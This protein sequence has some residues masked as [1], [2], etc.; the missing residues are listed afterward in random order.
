MSPAQIKPNVAFIGLCGMGMLMARRL[1]D[2]GWTVSGYDI[3][4]ATTAA[5][6]YAGGTASASPALAATNASIL[7]LMVARAEHIMS[8]LFAPRTG[9][10]HALTENATI[11]LHCTVQPT[12][13]Q[14]V[15]SRLGREYRR[16]DVVVM[17]APVIGSM[18]GVEDGTLTIMI[19]T[20]KVNYLE[21]PDI[22]DLLACMTQ[23]VHHIS[24]PLGS[25]LKVKLLN[26]ALCGIHIV[27]AAE[28]MGLAA[29]MALDT[30]RF[31]KFVTGP[32]PELGRR[33]NCWSWIFEDCVPRML[34]DK[35]P[36]GF[37]MRNV[38]RDVRIVNNEAEKFGA[39]LSL[40]KA[41]QFVYEE[42]VEMGFEDADDSAVLKTYLRRETSQGSDQTNFLQTVSELGGLWPEDEGACLYR[43]LCNALAAIHAMAAYEALVFAEGMHMCRSLKQCKQWIEI[44]GNATAGSTMFLDGM[45]RIFDSETHGT[46][47]LQLL[48]PRR[49]TLLESLVSST[50]NAD[51]VEGSLSKLTSRRRG[52]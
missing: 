50:T 45:P 4:P 36:L 26:Q 42:A 20:A 46:G 22:R 28:I 51:I 48:V 5:L 2:S 12:V 31:F 47:A 6:E 37:A 32:G 10:V 18:K 23:K 13:P 34:D 38:I 30:K 16:S 40:C 24:G 9:A 35:L 43:L 33:Q 8:A 52:K 41:S 3:N 11:I 39:R 27:A 14:D 29:V 15:R 7:V 49:E 17:D 25:A 19:S 44:L 21:R 1:I